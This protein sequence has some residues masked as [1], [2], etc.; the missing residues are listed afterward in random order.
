MAGSSALPTSKSKYLNAGAS[1]HAVDKVN[2]YLNIGQ[3]SQEG[4]QSW[5][6]KRDFAAYKRSGET[7]R[8]SKA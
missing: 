6:C 8:N 3:N 2:P 1:A 7:K 5:S 4:H